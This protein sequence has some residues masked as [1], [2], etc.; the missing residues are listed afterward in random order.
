MIVLKG[1]P[2]ST[3]RLYGH[4]SRGVHMTTEGKNTFGCKTDVVVFLPKS[5]G[6]LNLGF[7]API[8][9]TQYYL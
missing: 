8:L 6:G 4:H 9:F 1:K 7:K 5:K 3:N 2:Q